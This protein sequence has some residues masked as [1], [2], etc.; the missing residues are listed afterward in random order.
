MSSETREKMKGLNRWLSNNKQYKGGI[1]EPGIN[2]TW[3]IIKSVND[4]GTNI[5]QE[6]F[7]L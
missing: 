1:V 7:L 3:F 5:I 4:D 2:N 6:E